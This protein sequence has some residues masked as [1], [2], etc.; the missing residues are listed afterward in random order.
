[1]TPVSVHVE[2][3]KIS[4]VSPYRNNRSPL[5]TLTSIFGIKP[6][7]MECIP[8]V[9]THP[10]KR[11]LQVICVDIPPNKDELKRADANTVEQIR[12]Y[13]DGSAHDR[14]SGSSSN[15]KM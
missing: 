1:M 11:G 13:S 6:S 7:K 14:Q 3:N 2:I 10:K 5:H 12:V 8:P 9:H 15:T 4:R